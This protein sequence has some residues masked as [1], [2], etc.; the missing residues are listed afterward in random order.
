MYTHMEAVPDVS[1]NVLEPV[2]EQI[3]LY[4][5]DQIGFLNIFENNISLLFSGCISGPTAIRTKGEESGTG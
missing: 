3:V 5:I 1:A 2:A 4:I